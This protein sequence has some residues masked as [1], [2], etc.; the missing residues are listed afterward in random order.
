LKQLNSLGSKH[1]CE[2]IFKFEPLVISPAG[3]DDNLALLLSFAGA[4]GMV[5][6]L[7]IPPGFTVSGLFKEK[8]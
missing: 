8:I 7:V 6:F 2:I 4:I 3:P 1:R 5:L